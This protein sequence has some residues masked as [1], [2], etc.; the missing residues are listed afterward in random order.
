MARGRISHSPI[1][2]RRRPYKTLALPCECVIKKAGMDTGIVTRAKMAY[3]LCRGHVNFAI[4]TNAS[5][6]RFVSGTAA[7][8]TR[9]LTG[10]ARSKIVGWTRG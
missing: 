4:C 8:D 7:I 2:L 1:D 5:Y 9:S 10:V 3:A 6:V